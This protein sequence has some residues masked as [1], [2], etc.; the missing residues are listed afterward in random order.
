VHRLAAELSALLRLWHGL[1]RSV[2]LKIIKGTL[3]PAIGTWTL[4]IIVE[5]L[6]NTDP[7]IW[8][9]PD[10]GDLGRWQPGSQGHGSLYDI[11]ALEWSELSVRWSNEWQANHAALR[12]MTEPDFSFKVVQ[13]LR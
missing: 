12:K 13:R 5:A 3:C 11:V 8:N 2:P 1:D 10:C 7:S 9:S 6:R 4:I